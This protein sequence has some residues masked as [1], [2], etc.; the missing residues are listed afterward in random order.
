M[1]SNEGARRGWERR[2]EW[3][4]TV[5]AVVFLIAYAVPILDVHLAH[6]M[7]AIFAAVSVAIWVL[8]ALDYTVRLVL[9]GRRF[10]FVRRHLL[11]LAVIVL[12]IL[13]PLRVVRLVVAV[14]VLN[15]RA[16][17]SFRGRVA[18][19]VAATVALLVFV[20]SLAVL[21]AERGKPGANIQ[22]FGDAVWWAAATITTVGYGDRFPMTVQ[23]RL[24]AVGLM[25][26][27]IALL[28]VITAT[29]ATWFV[30]KVQ[31]EGARTQSDVGALCDEIRQLREEIGD[32][33]QRLDS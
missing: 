2:G 19:Y 5:L 13:R 1:L 6:D 12:P 22:D 20:A 17:G 11:D 33:R 10:T 18:V 32:F 8:F 21:D 25:V 30:E 7:R 9:A 4:L 26:A 3:P 31:Q 16:Q 29:L 23:G 24:V 27:G 14:S 28:G 15:R